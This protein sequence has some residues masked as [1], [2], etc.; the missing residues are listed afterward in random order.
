M[1]KNNVSNKATDQEKEDFW[2]KYVE[3]TLK[4]G[5]MAKGLVITQAGDT[6]SISDE[7]KNLDEY[8]NYKPQIMGSCG[9]VYPHSEGYNWSEI[10]KVEVVEE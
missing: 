6:I 5:N 1:E 3:I 8:K 4:D 10:D 2:G 7:F 9:V